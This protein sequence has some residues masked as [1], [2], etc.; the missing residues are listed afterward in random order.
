M[1]VAQISSI[2]VLIILIAL[3]AYKIYKAP[4]NQQRE[5]VKDLLDEVS[6]K[7]LDI[8]SDTIRK[9]D[10]SKQIDFTDFSSIVVSKMIDNAWEYVT[11]ELPKE[12]E[13][14]KELSILIKLITREQVENLVQ[15]LIDNND[16]QDIIADIFTNYYTAQFDKMEEEDKRLSQLA[17]D[18]ENETVEVP[19]YNGENDKSE[20]DI[21]KENF[22]GNPPKDEVVYSVD[23]DTIEILESSDIVDPLDNDLE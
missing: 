2:I 14:N 11:T 13:D 9:S 10:P 20:Y 22:V 23:D 3:V 17:E 19:E 6:D 8:I 4:S 18:Y 21:A 15:T 7:I 5:K 16:L 12:F 1:T